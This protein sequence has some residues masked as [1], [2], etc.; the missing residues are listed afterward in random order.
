LDQQD[1]EEA[2]GVDLFTGARPAGPDREMALAYVQAATEI[3]RLDDL[4]RRPFM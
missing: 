4:E 3:D 2:Y 1:P